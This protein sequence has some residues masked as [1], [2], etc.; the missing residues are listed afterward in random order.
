MCSRYVGTMLND[1]TLKQFFIQGFLKSGTIRNVLE[2]NPM[3]LVDA[4]IAAREVDQL[5]KDYEKLWRRENALIPQFIPIR[6]STLQGATIGQDG[7]VFYVPI[8][9]RPRPLA[10]F[11]TLPRKNDSR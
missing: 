7:Q 9:A 3:T 4:K 2:K 10:V 8:E 5:D 1:D 11:C 6:F